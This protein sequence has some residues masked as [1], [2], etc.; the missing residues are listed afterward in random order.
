MESTILNQ[1]HAFR[2]GRPTRPGC[3]MAS[4]K[5]ALLDSFVKLESQGT[6]RK[7]VM[8]VVFIGA[9]LTTASLF[10]SFTHP[11][12]RCRLPS[13]CGSRCCLQTLPKR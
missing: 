4:T 13:G 6:V 8:F 2:I 1:T 3:R 5:R 7:P 9:I 11:P 10:R 12:S